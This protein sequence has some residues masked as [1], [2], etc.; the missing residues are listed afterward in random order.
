MQS[1]EAETDINCLLC[2]VSVPGAFPALSHTFPTATEP[3]V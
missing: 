3:G 2:A 1:G